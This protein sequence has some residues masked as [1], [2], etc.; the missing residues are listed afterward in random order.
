MCEER[1]GERRLGCGKA[2]GR[3]ALTNVGGCDGVLAGVIVGSSGNTP[4]YTRS[5][6]SNDVSVPRATAKFVSRPLS[7]DRVVWPCL[8]RDLP[9]PSMHMARNEDDSGSQR[10]VIS[11]RLA[12]M[13]TGFFPEK[14]HKKKGDRERLGETTRAQSDRLGRCPAPRDFRSTTSRIHRDVPGANR[15]PRLQFPARV[16]GSRRGTS[17]LVSPGAAD[18]R[19][20]RRFSPPGLDGPITARDL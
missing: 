11:V 20:L 2:R 18:C 10:R 4:S 12:V 16:N 7:L 5:P 17:G 15:R 9:D 13:I 19:T 6:V 14:N 3:A 8:Q 1:T